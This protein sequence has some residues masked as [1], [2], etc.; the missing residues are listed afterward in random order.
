MLMQHNTCDCCTTVEKVL[1]ALPLIIPERIP[2]GHHF[3]SVS[4]SVQA[5]MIHKLM[6][7]LSE[8]QGEARAYLG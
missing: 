6:T 3:S 7:G 5:A 1:D 4:S 2:A 8:N